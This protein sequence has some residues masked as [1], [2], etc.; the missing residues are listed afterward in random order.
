MA[1]LNHS[2]LLL[3]RIENRQFLEKEPVE[4]K[5]LVDAKMELWQEWIREHDLEVVLELQPETVW[6]HPFLAESL[7]NNLLSNAVRHNIP[8]GAIL[9]T[10]LPG[11]FSVKNTGQRGALDPKGLFQRFQKQYPSEGVGLGLAIVKEIVEMSGMEV[12]YSY[13]EGAHTFTV[14]F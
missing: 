2:L 1:R 14:T 3:T 13:E 5:A 7:V 12:R 8:R 10:L 4:L 9:V 6:M 11:L